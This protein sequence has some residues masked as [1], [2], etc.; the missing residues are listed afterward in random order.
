MSSP[1]DLP[2]GITQF[3]D[4]AHLTSVN[5]AK[6]RFRHNVLGWQ[7]TLWG[8]EALVCRWGRIGA[9]GKSRFSLYPDRASAQET[10]T[11]VIRRRLQHKYQVVDWR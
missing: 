4:Y 10:I 2:A 7:P 8:Q 6:R 3:E 9:V 11:R 5:P 1:V